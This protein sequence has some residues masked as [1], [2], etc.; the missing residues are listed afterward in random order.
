MGIFNKNR[1]GGGKPKPAHRIPAK[2]SKARARAHLEVQ[3]RPDSVQA[4][5]DEIR[6]RAGLPPIESRFTRQ[7]RELVGEIGKPAEPVAD[8]ETRAADLA[9]RR[10]AHDRKAAAMDAELR[11]IIAAAQAER[12]VSAVARRLGLSRQRLYQIA[13]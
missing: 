7:C 6:A 4:V 1:C 9:R 12:K 10:A 13:A 2:L 8:A 3:A 5:S 11:E